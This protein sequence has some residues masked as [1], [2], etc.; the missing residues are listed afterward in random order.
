[1]HRPFSFSIQAMFRYLS[2]KPVTAWP[3]QRS[4]AIEHLS[5][6]RPGDAPRQEKIK[7]KPGESENR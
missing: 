7:A 6:P 4:T 5:N 3:G 1:M 2:D